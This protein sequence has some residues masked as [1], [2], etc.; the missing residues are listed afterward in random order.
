VYNIHSF[1]VNVVMLMVFAISM[2]NVYYK[3]D[4]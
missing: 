4:G 3:M 2:N 1:A